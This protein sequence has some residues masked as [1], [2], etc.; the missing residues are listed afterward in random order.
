VTQIGEGA[1]LKWNSLTEVTISPSNPAYRVLDGV[2]FSSTLAELILYPRFKSDTQY[3]IPQGVEHIGIG[4]FFGNSFLQSVTMPHTV[5]TIASEAFA[6]M[7]I[8]SIVLSE[9]LQTIVTQTFSGSSSLTSIA[10]PDS[11]LSIEM[12]AFYGCNGLT[13]VSIGSGLTL[14]DSDAFEASI[15]LEAFD[16]APENLVFR[17][18]SGVLFSKDMEVLIFYPMAKPEETYVIPSGVKTIGDHAFAGIRRLKH[19]ILGADVET[20][21]YQAFLNGFSLEEVTFNLKL[22]TIEKE[23][24]R[25]CVNLISIALPDSLRTIGEAAFRGCSGLINVHLGNGVET[26]GWAA[27]LGCYA[28]DEIIIPASVTVIENYVFEGCPFLTIR[29]RAAL[30]PAEWM[31]KWDHHNHAENLRCTVIWNDS[32]S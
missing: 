23:A 2:L 9:S 22:T 11:V 3:A 21:G 17:S 12:R 16:V 6:S 29:V 10:I 1:F 25:G 19:T 7:S 28:L 20:I 24:F 18:V 15:N 8:E 31:D 13:H 27:F 30:K 26:I 5:L 4:A 14:I 32:G